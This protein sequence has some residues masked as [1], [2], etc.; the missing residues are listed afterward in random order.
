MAIET[1][2]KSLVAGAFNRK[3]LVEGWMNGHLVWSKGL[4][5]IKQMNPNKLFLWLSAPSSQK[6]YRYDYITGVIDSMVATAAGTVTTNVDPSTCGVTK[7]FSSGTS[8]L[9]G[10]SSTIITNLNLVPEVGGYIK[11]MA[12]RSSVWSI[13]FAFFSGNIDDVGTRNDN[14]FTQ[15]GSESY[16]SLQFGNVYDNTS[17]VIA[18]KLKASLINTTSTAVQASKLLRTDWRYGKYLMNDKGHGFNIVIIIKNGSTFTFFFNGLTG[19]FMVPGTSTTVLDSV[20]S[21]SSVYSILFNDQ[22]ADSG[23]N[24]PNFKNIYSDLAFYNR[25]LT[26]FEC[27]EIFKLYNSKNLPYKKSDSS[28]T[29]AN[30]VLFKIV[31]VNETGEDLPLNLFSSMKIFKTSM[32]DYTVTNTDENG[33]YWGY[34]IGNNN[35]NP[36][37][38]NTCE[39]IM[40]S[41]SSFDKFTYTSTLNGG[42]YE[43]NLEGLNTGTSF[44][45]VLLRD[46]Q[47][48]SGENIFVTTITSVTKEVAKLPTAINIVFSASTM[49]I[50]SNDWAQ[51]A[52][53]SM[54]MKINGDATGTQVFFRIPL[55]TLMNNGH[56]SIDL[57]NIT[58]IEEIEFILETPEGTT[59]EYVFCV[60]SMPMPSAHPDNILVKGYYINYRTGV[61]GT[62]VKPCFDWYDRKGQVYPCVFMLGYR[63]SALG[64]EIEA[65]QMTNEC[66]EDLGM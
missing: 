4:T 1:G 2:G 22:G 48:I 38:T 10:L 28:K 30:N 61:G 66:L 53:L 39:W 46:V 47:L 26:E 43:S 35:F 54:F 40:P 42:D 65:T 17:G 32:G 15:F 20:S 63:D 60:T 56:R 41:N 45:A 44:N 12:L 23:V 49:Q 31:I 16:G 11:Q 3:D 18:S 29:C 27:F 33:N 36:D 6:S 14:K 8:V 58:S 7:A 62:I 57:S 21:A 64:A 51:L 59:K 5:D 25:A 9:P 34:A 13:S 24:P 50:E 19:S 52:T 55:S 37:G